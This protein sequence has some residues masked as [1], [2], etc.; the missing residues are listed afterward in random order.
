MK[1]LLNTLFVTTQGS[2]LS[3]EGETIL[4]KAGEE[5]RLRIPIHTLE[6]V[7]CFGQVSC[8][9][10]LMGLCADR[11]VK[12]SFLTES[13]RFLARVEGGVHGNVLLRRAQYRAA[14]DETLTTGIARAIVT[15]KV[16]NAR[17][18]LLRGLREHSVEI[19][20]RPALED[21][22]KRL[23]QSLEEINRVPTLNGV[24]GIE[25]VS[26][27]T[28]FCVLDQLITTSKEQF[29]L[30]TRSRRPPLDNVN[31]LLSFVYTLLVHDCVGALEAVGLDPQVG[32]LHTDR[33]GRPSLALDLME[34]FRPFLA[35]RL[36]LSLINRR[37]VT[38]DGFRRTEAGGVVM[39]D[40]TRKQ[41][42]VGWQERK[43]EELMHPFI[44][45]RVA[46]GLL[47]YLQA[48]LLA[49]RLR[50]DLDGYP[51]FF[52]R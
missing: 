13:G 22:I 41:V 40:A 48:L 38:A 21:A 9:P 10:W 19:Q 12:M 8:S 39:D 4:V 35:D 23:A 44:Q 2:Y 28:Y 51:P 7:I 30:R 29:F 43:Q 31:A 1:P 6:S 49:R 27:Q 37:Q 17:T 45:E 52:C 34:E 50:G 11:S 15:A 3:K 24:R 42:L 18:V 14:D 33:P 47:P 20:H 16:A 5:V 25:G 36:V 26:A 32:Y 46:V